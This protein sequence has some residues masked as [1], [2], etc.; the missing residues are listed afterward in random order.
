MKKPLNIIIVTIKSIF[1]WIN[2]V[3]RFIS[4]EIHLLVTKYKAQKISLMIIPHR[5]ARLFLLA[6]IKYIV[7]FLLI[8]TLIIS[9]TYVSSLFNK[10][11]LK[12]KVSSL[13]EKKKIVFY[14]RQ[15]FLE[16]AKQITKYKDDL[17][18]NIID[19]YKKSNI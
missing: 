2:K 14:E 15:L 17:K 8:F 11:I 19:I 5:Q 10:K 12:T 13:K 9:I 16:K 7:Y 6:L 4:N 1:T 18:K 3:Y